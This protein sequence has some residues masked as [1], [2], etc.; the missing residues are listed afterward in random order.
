MEKRARKRYPVPGDVTGRAVL[1]ADVDIH[2]LSFGG[3]RFKCYERVLPHTKIKLVLNR[4][5]LQVTVH[6]DVLRSSLKHRKEPGDE[7]DSFYEV[8]VSFKS[9]DG[10][11]QEVLEKLI[12]RLEKENNS[13]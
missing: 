9:I 8:A 2:D 11:N 12:D 6:C 7:G 5:D 4:K 3:M 10:S 1:V 13:T